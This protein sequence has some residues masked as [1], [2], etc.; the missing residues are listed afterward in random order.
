VEGE[1]KRYRLAMNKEGWGEGE[2]EGEREGEGEMEGEGKVTE[3]CGKTMMM[4]RYH[5][6]VMLQHLCAFL[7]RC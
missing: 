2:G 4:Y 5:W 7:W 6:Q 3:K 1:G